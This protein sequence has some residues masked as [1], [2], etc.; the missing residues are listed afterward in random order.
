MPRK[1]S[2]AV[3]LVIV[4]GLLGLIVWGIVRGIHEDPALVAT[5]LTAGVTVVGG[6]GV[7]GYQGRVQR[8]ETAERIRREKITDYYE[9]LIKY[10][11]DM[12]EHA[13]LEEPSEIATTGADEPG[14]E[15]TVQ[16]VAAPR[17]SRRW[18]ACPP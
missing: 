3:G 17:H 4:L 14:V 18:P 13:D 12:A 10:V 16:R 7:A 11:S 8:R 1:L 2:T 6:I 5:V 9:A 15:Q